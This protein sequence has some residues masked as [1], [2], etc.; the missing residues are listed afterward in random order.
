[1]IPFDEKMFT[2][3]QYLFDISTTWQYMLVAAGISFVFWILVLIIEKLTNDKVRRI[4][5]RYFYRPVVWICS[6]VIFVGAF[7]Y[8]IVIL[9]DYIWGVG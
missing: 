1:M 9:K 8:L 6:F 7:Y 5:E 2:S 4:I 3:T